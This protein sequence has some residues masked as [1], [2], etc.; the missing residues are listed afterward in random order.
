MIATSKKS[1]RKISKDSRKRTS[2]PGSE[3]G[4]TRCVK[5]DGPML[6][7]FGREVV[8][9]PA[10][11]PQE[12][13]K[14]LMTL[15]TSGLIGQDSSASASLQQSLASKL[16][17]RLDSAG[18]TLFSRIWRREITPLGRQ[19]L[20]RAMSELRTSDQGSTLWPSPSRRDES[21]SKRHGYMDKGHPGTTLC[22]AVDQTSAWPTPVAND[23]NKEAGN[24]DSSRRTVELASWPTPDSMSGGGESA[25]RKKELGRME[26]GGGDPEAVAHWATPDADTGP[27]GPR[28]TSKNPANQS[29]RDLQA[30][31]QWATPANRD[32]RHP[33]ARSY[34]ERSGTKKG[35]Q[36]PNQ[37]QHWTT[38]QAHDSTARSKGQKAKHGT[39]HGCAD[40]NADANLSGPEQSG[41]TAATAS[42]VRYLLNP[43]F[44][45]W[46]QG[47]PEEWASCG[48]RA[49]LC[50]RR[51]RKNSSKRTSR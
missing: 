13:G 39:K 38:P 12:K 14:A 9:A 5:P 42:G 26:S 22:D 50:A 18:S 34:Q 49:M 32:Y 44:S 6:D 11:Q 27:H 2:L 31:A 43:R 10:S 35:E 33:N 7:L 29:G 21:N 41:T 28:G 20:E 51:R 45:L 36:M 8:L 40:L 47:L 46:L 15:V 30:Q 19:Y 17:T 3:S 24:T 37:V 4:P 25:E 48:E 23:D 1:P 16:M